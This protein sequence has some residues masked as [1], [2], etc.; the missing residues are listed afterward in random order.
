ML[1]PIAAMLAG[2]KYD[3]SKIW[4]ELEAQKAKI[5]ALESLNSNV[6]SLQSIVNALQ[7]NITVTAVTTNENGHNVSFSDGTTVTIL[8]AEAA[9]PKLGARQD[10]DGIYYW[11]VGGNWLLDSGGDKVPTTGK[12]PKLKV[13]GDQWMVSYNDGSTWAK[14]DGQTSTLCLFESVTTDASKAVFTLSDGWRR[15]RLK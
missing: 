5:A 3:D 10:S 8:N 1:L 14:V 11:T 15:R 6:S 9:A 13:E 4:E 2:C 12:T 7:K